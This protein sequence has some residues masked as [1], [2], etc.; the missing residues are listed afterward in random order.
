MEEFVQKGE[1]IETGNPQI[2]MFLSD[3]RS[4]NKPDLITENYSVLSSQDLTLL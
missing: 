1:K 4:G 2:E 3:L